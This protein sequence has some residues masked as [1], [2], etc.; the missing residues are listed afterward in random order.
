M[1]IAGSTSTSS[2]FS[3]TNS[4]SAV[5]T[6][7]IWHQAIAEVASGLDAETLEV[8]S[9]AGHDAQQLARLAPIGMIFVPS[10]GGISHNAA[11]TTGPDQRHRAQRFARFA[12]RGR[13]VPGPVNWRP[14]EQGPPRDR[15]VRWHPTGPTL[16]GP[17]FNSGAVR[18][19]LRRGRR[20]HHPRWRYHLRD[21]PFRNDRRRGFPRPAHEHGIALRVR[22]PRWLLAG[23]TPSS[24]DTT[25]RSQSS[26][27]RRP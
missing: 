2:A 1:K 22:Q 26:P 9:G 5:A 23:T 14:S 12:P 8:A 25:C 17:S 4:T 10:A 7:K 15:R 13:R 18:A 20:A 19:Q 6:D 16:A 3:L 11:E 24:N 27:W 21:F